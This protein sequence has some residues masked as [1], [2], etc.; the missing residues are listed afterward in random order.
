MPLF[1]QIFL[2]NYIRCVTKAACYDAAARPNTVGRYRLV[3]Y[4]RA[5]SCTVILRHQYAKTEIFFLY[6]IF[7][8]LSCENFLKSQ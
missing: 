8:E 3:W 7:I 2:G 4:Y 6:S 5:I 1:P